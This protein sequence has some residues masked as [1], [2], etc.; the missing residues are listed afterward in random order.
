MIG[1]VGKQGERGIPGPT[2]PSGPAGPVGATGATGATGPQGPQGLQG[3]AGPAGPAGSNGSTG[4]QGPQG[5]QGP[6]GTSSPWTISGNNTLYN[7]GRV[8]IG[9]TDPIDLLHVSSTGNNTILAFNSLTTGAGLYAWN[10]ST[11]GINF[12]VRGRS[13]SPTGIGVYG[14]SPGIAT[15]GESTTP[16]GIGIYGV[17]SAQSGNAF[18]VQ[19]LSGSSTGTGTYGNGN[20]NGVWGETNNVAGRGVYG[21][22][23]STTGSTAY[24]VQGQSSSSAGVGVFGSSPFTGVQGS[25]SSA[26]GRALVAISSATS[27]AN[28]GLLATNASDSGI[29]ISGRALSTNSSTNTRIGVYGEAPA[30]TN[31]WAGF[32][33]GNLNVTGSIFG[34]S[35]SFRIDHPLD[36]ANKYLNHVSIESPDMKNF[37]DGVAI[38]DAAGRATVS[39]PDWFE[40]LNGDFRYQLTCVGGFAPVYIAREIENNQ[41]VIE[42]GTAGL[43]VSWAVTGIRRDA[44][45][46]SH[47]V[48]V[49]E[50]KGPS[51][52]G[53]Y[54]SP[55]SFGMPESLRIGPPATQP[56]PAVGEAG[57]VA[58][59]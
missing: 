32:F 31:S 19:G 14:Y 2:G 22:N 46:N 18:G 44:W 20:L 52:R 36:P 34:A 17:N 57:E 43:K 15:Q 29:A 3:P 55:E 38:L 9:V 45:S 5:P 10:T 6:A 41:F 58:S 26:T 54:L 37:Y 28:F 42:G 21:N 59:R 4:P 1:P 23:T 39:L 16:N 33:Q 35:K 27:G 12:G 49:E 40:A 51:E 7:Q 53:K 8:G 47:R 50:L 30:Q 48:P 56:S 25:V 24:G 13:D 11:S